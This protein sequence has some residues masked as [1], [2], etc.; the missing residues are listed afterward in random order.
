MKSSVSRKRRFPVEPPFFFDL[1][2][3]HDRA[4]IAESLSDNMLLF[5]WPL[6]TRWLGRVR[7]AMLAASQAGA[8]A[9]QRLNK[10]HPEGW[11]LSAGWCVAALG[12]CAAS[13]GGPLL[14]SDSTIANENSN[15]FPN[16][17]LEFGSAFRGGSFPV[18]WPA[19]RH[20]GPNAE[21]AFQT[22]LAALQFDQRLRHRQSQACPALQR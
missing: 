19:N 15:I 6:F 7:A 1:N 13:P 5:S 9:V 18:D 17:L 21:L 11:R 4:W 16:G 22:E 10:G 12:R 2:L 3:R 20:R 14:P 8:D